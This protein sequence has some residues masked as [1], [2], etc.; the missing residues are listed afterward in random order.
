MIWIS[1][2]RWLIAIVAAVLSA[3]GGGSA[4]DVPPTAVI[5]STAQALASTSPLSKQVV[6]GG[7]VSLDASGSA[8]GTAPIVR[9]SWSMTSMP[10]GS[11]AVIAA[12]AAART[13]VN[14]DVVGTYV[15]KLLVTDAN[16]LS[17]ST[18]LTLNAGQ[19]PVNS[20][21][22]AVSFNAP[23]VTY[24]DTAAFVGSLVTLDASASHDPG[25]GALALSWQMQS[26]PA[27]STAALAS[28]GNAA[29][30]TID[31]V[32]RYQVLVRATGPSGAHSDA[33]YVYVAT[34]EAPRM[35]VA[36]TVDT[37][38]GTQS[39]TAA[40]GNLVSL[41]G[42]GSSGV[43]GGSETMSWTL[44]AKPAGSAAALSTSA[45]GSSAR[46]VP[47]ALG[48]YSARFTVLDSA[49]G[50]S[51]FQ[52]VNVAVM[53][54]PTAVVSASA[55]PVASVNGPTYVATAGVP[56]TVRGSG[57]FDPSG[58]ALGYQWTML[59]RPAGSASVLATTSA[60]DT[61]FT[62][63]V[64]GRYVLE[65]TVTS[66]ASLVTLQRMNVDVGSFPPVAIVDRAQLV[67]LVGGSVSASAASSYSNSGHALTYRW[68]I[69]ARPA[70]STAVIA[71]PD[72]ATLVFKPDFAGTYYATVTVSDSPFNAVASVTIVAYGASSG[73]VPLTYRPLVS[74]FSKALGKAVIVSDYPNAL[75]IVDPGA[76][77]DVAVALP[78]AVKMMSL[79][80]DGGL[81]AVLHEG[82][83][84]LV[85]VNGGVL[86]RSSATGGSQS[87]AFVDNGG[88]IYL[89]GQTGG[90][91]VTPGFTVINGRTGLQVQTYDAFGSFYGT[92]YGVYS[93]AAGKIFTQSD[94]LSPSKVYATTVQAGTGLLLATSAMPYHGDYAS[95]NPLWLS[96]DQGLLF[97]AAGTYFKTSDLTYA[98]TLGR[99]MRS[100]SHSSTASE[101]VAL[102]NDSL[103]I[104]WWSTNYPSVLKH[105]QGSLLF[106]ASDIPL[107][108][109]AGSQ[110]CGIAVFHRSDDRL[111]IVVQTGSDQ[112]EATGAAYYLI[113]R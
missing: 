75:H 53:Q 31:T 108:L 22:T 104:G 90:Q 17:S 76:A 63:D 52:V 96:G 109:V 91:W 56:V 20:V 27:A 102:Q 66:T 12:A 3:C 84:S 37:L 55:S 46:F 4:P 58:A 45:D 101:A 41:D 26:R 79:S 77:T 81:A 111:V 99:P 18:E 42:R 35:V 40:V 11:Q 62:P 6:V 83:V 65:L 24:P 54:G 87:D 71:A 105:Y 51:A 13:T 1:R 5:Q 110:A 34:A 80:P 82:T 85:D 25:G 64:N 48:A 61:N 50:R 68:A 112:V 93:D 107:P 103:Y 113:L 95:A 36:S 33:I 98:G 92:T 2:N 74:R 16:E 78:A 89:V 43:L 59:S 23:S 67:T 88:T 106:P 39:L 57:S 7:T 29:R 28:S 38:G 60:A 19:P 9:Y 47:D 21:T 8:S 14:P 49:T 10:S 100:V 86:V 94:G 30:F 69:D 15:V 73:T 70:G 97:T 44:L 32:G 72:A